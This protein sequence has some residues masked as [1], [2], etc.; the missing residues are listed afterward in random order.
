MRWRLRG[1]LQ[2]LTMRPTS[3]RTGFAGKESKPFVK[4]VRVCR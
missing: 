1:E 4:R 2:Y 3:V